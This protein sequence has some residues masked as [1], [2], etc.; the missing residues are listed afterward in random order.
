M[1]DKATPMAEVLI[2]DDDPLI[3]NLMREVLMDLGLQVKCFPDGG[4]AV[5]HIKDEKP[6]L[7]LVDL[8]MPGLDGVSICMLVRKDP[9][10]SATK[11]VVVT[12][13]GFK[14]DRDNALKVGAAD[15]FVEK[16]FDVDDFARQMIGLLKVRPTA[17]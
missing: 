7:V 9:A 17:G 8:M 2:F 3:S 10:I 11:M 6:K 15:L 5:Q 12:G 16:P 1:R 4:D 13:K 14:E